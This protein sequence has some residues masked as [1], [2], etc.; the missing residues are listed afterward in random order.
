MK[1]LILHDQLNPTRQVPMD[2]EDFS[3][4]QPAGSGSV[5]RTKSSD[6][7]IFVK[8]TPEEIID[9]IERLQA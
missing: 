7:G 9:S 4:A 6:A 1:L 5:V 2:V 3:T 8:E